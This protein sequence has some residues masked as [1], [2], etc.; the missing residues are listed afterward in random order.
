LAFIGSIS[1]KSFATK[2][3]DSLPE[4]IVC[5]SLIGIQFMSEILPRLHLGCSP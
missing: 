1:S 2:T 4:H 3:P 5:L